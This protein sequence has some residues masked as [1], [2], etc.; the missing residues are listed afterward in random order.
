[1]EKL[2][3][4][5][6]RRITDEKVGQHV[7]HIPPIY[8]KSMQEFDAFVRDVKKQIETYGTQEIAFYGK[9]GP[10]TPLEYELS[11]IRRA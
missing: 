4:V 1:M 11:V 8:F 3:K 9:L 5:K 10:E 7:P 2:G 6:E